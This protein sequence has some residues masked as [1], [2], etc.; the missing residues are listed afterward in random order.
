MAPVLIATFMN[1]KIL[2]LF[3]CGNLFSLFAHPQ[4]Q[5]EGIVFVKTMAENVVITDTGTILDLTATIL[6]EPRWHVSSSI[7]DEAAYKPVEMYADPERSC[8]Q[9]T[10]PISETGKL[11]EFYD[12]LMMGQVRYFDGSVTF[13]I[14]LY[15]PGNCDL[16]KNK[17]I[18]EY[19][20]C[21]DPENGG[22][23]IFPVV[24]IDVRQLL[25]NG[26]QK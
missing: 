9:I 16:S 20:A 24:V 11:V 8:L 17:I 1:N 14:P 2:L 5:T 3:V 19:Q 18:L 22:K 15:F 13:R 23:C 25:E 4:N 21:I 10:G 26:D 7:E 12:D 6:P